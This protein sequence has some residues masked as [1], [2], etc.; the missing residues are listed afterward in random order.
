M[1]ARHHTHIV[2]FITICPFTLLVQSSSKEMRARVG[3]FTCGRRGDDD[4]VGFISGLSVTSCWQWGWCWCYPGYS[5]W[6]DN[7]HFS[8]KTFSLPALELTLR[9]QPTS[10]ISRGPHTHTRSYACGSQ[11]HK[12]GIPRGGELEHYYHHHQ[13]RQKQ[14]EQHQPQTFAIRLA[15]QTV[16]RFS[17]P[18]RHKVVVAVKTAARGRKTKEMALNCWNKIIS[19]LINEFSTLLLTKL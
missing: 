8:Y 9:D 17:W 6:N 1:R 2:I 7:Y 11:Q 10:T 14:Q 18:T 5:H 16:R 12:E 4:G 3:W 13:Q 19:G 15:G